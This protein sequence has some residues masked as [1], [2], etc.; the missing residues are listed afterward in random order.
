MTILFGI[1]KWGWVKREHPRWVN[2]NI[3]EYVRDVVDNTTKTTFV[4]PLVDGEGG[5]QY[6]AGTWRAADWL[7]TD[8]NDNAPNKQ[9]LRKNRTAAILLAASRLDQCV[10]FGLLEEIDRS[11]TLL[12]ATLGTNTGPTMGK[13]NGAKNAHPPPSNETKR[14]IERYLPQDIWLYQY[15]QRL[16]EARW[17]YFIENQTYVHPEMP[18]FPDFSRPIAFADK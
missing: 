17:N 8:G 2:Q 13:A 7:K 14:L 5:L 15:A 1:V 11:L 16:F 3:D 9:Y 6:L 18:P 10:W 4:Q 12:Q